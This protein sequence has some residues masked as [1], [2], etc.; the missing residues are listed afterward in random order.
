MPLTT[1]E[2]L[3]SEGLRAWVLSTLGGWLVALLLVYLGE[4]GLQPPPPAA[5]LL[6][7]PPDEQP[8]A[9]TPRPAEAD[10][11]YR[12]LLAA[13]PTVSPAAEPEPVPQPSLVVADPVGVNLRAEPAMASPV[14]AT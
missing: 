5:S 11:S 9:L 3:V 12:A 8:R 7:L 10:G 6:R 1:R 14:I 4:R 2:V 13:L